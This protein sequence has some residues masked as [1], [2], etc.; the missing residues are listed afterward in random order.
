MRVFRR[1]AAVGESEALDMY[2]LAFLAGGVQRVADSAVVALSEAGSLRMRG[3][4]VRALGE[5]RRPEHPV[6][7]AV[8]AWCTRSRS[9]ASVPTALR[10]SPE[11]EEI[12]RRL[13]TRGLVTG[14]RRRPTRAGR[15]R[16]RSAQHDESLPAYVLD[17]PATLSRGPVRRG[18]LNAHPLPSGLGRTLTRMGRTLDRDSDLDTT[19]STPDW[20][21]G[22]SCGGGGGGGGD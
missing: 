7:R 8:I 14:T 11:V 16:L 6:E 18:V 10:T 15:R 9:I 22:F 12:G 2:D 19:D 17:G 3:S 21:G 5:A 4:R 20:G 13:A 1:S